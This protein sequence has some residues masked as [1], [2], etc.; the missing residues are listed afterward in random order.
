[1]ISRTSL[2][3]VRAVVALA[4]LPQGKFAGAAYIARS[5]GAPENYLGKLL[6]TLAKA[7][8]V[9]SQ[10]GLGGGFRLASE[11]QLI[12]LYDVVEPIDQISRWSSCILGHN[13]CS[14]EAGCPMHEQWKKV[15]GN[16]LRMLATTTIGQLAAK[17]E[18]VLQRR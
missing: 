1:M 9:E 5:V 3:A 13:E 6:K 2:Y 15:R 8:L 14:D 16:Y 11:P 10:K 7:G 18:P 12:S 17:G 4:K